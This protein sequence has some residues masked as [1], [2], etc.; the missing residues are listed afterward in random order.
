M[1]SSG[2]IGLIKSASVSVSESISLSVY[3]TSLT[4]YTEST[5]R[6]LQPIFLYQ[7]AHQGTVPMRYGYLLFLVEIRNIY[8]LATPEME[9]TV[10]IGII[11]ETTL[12]KTMRDTMLVSIEM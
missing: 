3:K 10:R 6:N 2:E 4:P 9:L 1:P 8:V 5:D 11:R 7:T 12:S